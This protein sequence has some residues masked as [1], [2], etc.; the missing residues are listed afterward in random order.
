MRKLLA[1]K[2]NGSAAQLP[3]PTAR[4]QIDTPG[5][6]CL[7]SHLTPSAGGFGLQDV[8]K[9]V[10]VTA[11]LKCFYEYKENTNHQG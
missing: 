7:P 3:H 4:N 10:H 5:P 1:A 6:P 9:T 11:D 8:L 2:A